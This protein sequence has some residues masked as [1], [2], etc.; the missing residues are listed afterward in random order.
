MS[1]K[2]IT[3][4]SAAAVAVAGLTASQASAMDKRTRNVILGATAL[5]ILGAAASQADSN[6]GYVTRHYDDRNHPRPGNGHGHGNGHSHSNGNHQGHVHNDHPRG[7]APGIHPRPVPPRVI[8]SELPDRCAFTVGTRNGPARMFETRC[9][10]R[11]YSQANRLP[12]SC[13]RTV[14]LGSKTVD[15]YGGACLRER[16]GNTAWLNRH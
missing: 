15:A 6:D 2:F 12:N 16:S 4:V 7:P 3:L 9:L 14:K 13:R 10:Q 8:F 5:A 1:R 11:N